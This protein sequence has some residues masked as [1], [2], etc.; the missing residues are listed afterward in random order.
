MSLVCTHSGKKWK[1]RTDFRAITF[2][3]KSVRESFIS[4]EG[5]VTLVSSLYVPEF[6]AIPPV[7]CKEVSH[8]TEDGRKA[9]QTL[10]Y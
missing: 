5:E 2:S 7:K 9:V 4:H 10:V 3:K 8:I 1:K 6:T